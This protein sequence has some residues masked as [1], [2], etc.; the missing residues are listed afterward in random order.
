MEIVSYESIG[1]LKFGDSLESIRKKLSK[2]RGVKQIDK[3][4]MDK[5][6]PSIYVKDI[7]LF[8]VFNEDFS[9]V[10]Y[11]E[12]EHD[13][14][15]Q[16]INLYSESIKKLESL[17]REL[18]PEILIESDGFDSH[19]FGLCVTQL[20]S[21]NKNNILIYSKDYLNEDEITEDDILKFYL[22]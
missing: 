3:V 7:N 8:I 13:I 9:S 15:H 18:D 14:Y 12:I 2:Y 11:F 10:R 21:G 5:V 4:V 6:Y 17:Y 16:G 22:G 19:K 1:D 20:G